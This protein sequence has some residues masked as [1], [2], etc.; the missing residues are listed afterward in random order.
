VEQYERLKQLVN[1]MDDDIRKAEGG[2]KAAGT[3]VRQTLQEVKNLAQD[4][5][6]SV[7]EMRK[8]NE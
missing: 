1:E 7:L 3:R 2:N 6:K 8:P 4:M 5:R